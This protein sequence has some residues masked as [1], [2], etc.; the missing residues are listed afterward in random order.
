METYKVTRHDY[1][2]LLTSITKCVIS[3]YSYNCTNN[4]LVEFVQM[5]MRSSLERTKE[6]HYHVYKHTCVDLQV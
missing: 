1:K 4:K 3:L 5:Q 2:S 6:I